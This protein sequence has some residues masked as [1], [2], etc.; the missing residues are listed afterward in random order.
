MVRHWMVIV[1]FCLCTSFR[2]AADQYD[3]CDTITFYDGQKFTIIGKFHDEKGYAR[4]PARYENL[5]RPEVWRRGQRSAGIS[6]FFYTN[7][8]D[9]VAR[10]TIASE[11]NNTYMATTGVRGIDLYANVGGVWRFIQTG[12]P[13]GRTSEHVLLTE[14]T[15]VYREFLL[16]LPL[17]D[18]VDS[19]SIG[20]NIGADIS[21][22]VSS[23]FTGKPIVHY[24][25]SITQGACA[26]RPGMAYTN[27]L[28]RKLGRSYI[29]F[30]FNGQGT[31]D[32]SVGQAMCEIDAALYVVDCNPNTDETLIYDRAIKLVKQLKECQPNVPV[33]LMENYASTGEYFY[34]GY[35]DTQGNVNFVNK[36]QD[37]LRKAF[38][39]LK[40]SGI[41]Q[42][43]YQEG[44]DLIGLDQEGTGDGSHPNDLGMFR[45]AEILFPTI[46][47]ILKE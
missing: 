8:T 43:Y 2:C 6:I 10:W 19:L 23:S 5:L 29:N 14:R 38:E 46:K 7:A 28:A 41:T 3:K 47:E 22:P 4:F 45:I 36:K 39:T 26:S 31:F 11:T 13:K 20:V 32:E 9:I 30:G 16:N 33:L 27:I 25:S 12:D 44:K 17:Y 24:G 15:P 35:P 34:K 18:G 21:K 40:K 1:L 37:E 42:L